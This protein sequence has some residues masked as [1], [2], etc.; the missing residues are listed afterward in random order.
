MLCSRVLGRERRLVRVIHMSEQTIIDPAFL[1]ILRANIAS[2]DVAVW[3][4]GG[5]LR[6]AL[7]QRTSLDIDLAVDGDA[8]GFARALADATGGSWLLLDDERDTARIV[9]SDDKRGAGWPEVVDVARL[10]APTIEADLYDR[11]FTI[12]AL[13]LP[14]TAAPLDIAQ[15][16]D[17]TGGMDD[18]R[19]RRL[20]RSNPAAFERD[21][22][23]MLRAVRFAA[24]LDFAIDAE[25]EAGLREQYRSIE[26]ISHER[27][28]DELMKVL[29]LP[30][31]GRW[32]R[33][34]DD[35]CLL[36]A[37]IPELEAG[38]T[39]EQPSMH[40]FPVLHHQI[41]AV[42]CADWLL[43][44]VDED[45]GVARAR[46]TH[47]EPSALTP[48][49][50]LSANF[51]YAER[52][53]AHFSTIVDGVSRR[54][55]F[56]LAVLLHDVAKPQTKARKPDGGISFYDHQT[57]GA[58]IA[59]DIARRL[60]LSRAASEY[61]RLVVREHMRPGQLNELGR[62]LTSRAIYRFFRATGAFGPDVLLHSL[63]D[64]LGMKGPLLDRGGWYNHVH[65]TAHLF[66][67]FYVEQ[68]NPPP[69]VVRG[70]DLLHLGIPQGPLI[71]HLLEE[72]REAQAMGEVK[73]RDEAL[74][75]I[76]RRNAEAT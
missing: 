54:A 8:S 27:I 33:Y 67:T 51:P 69:A 32:V 37:I 20:R 19:H 9:W 74:A 73:T 53:H 40:A 2:H 26:R 5:S 65:W 38:R 50:S 68:T 71:G 48:H 24:M 4:V 47:T 45:A 1:E 35:V 11:D 39:C 17:P 15:I 14:L 49:P 30:D 22:A 46:A 23:R 52:L 43:M 21:P 6:D 64:H 12:N 61:V 10:R 62:D 16:I 56:K 7:L 18:L 41:E 59:F 66:E 3:L 42:V 60:R 72:V 34:L 57:I 36:T 58:D 29:A 13:A 76:R 70:E 25:L 55:L 28:R 75:L 31:A 63:C 44:Q